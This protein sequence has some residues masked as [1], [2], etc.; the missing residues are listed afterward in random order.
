MIL[1]GHEN[2]V[3]V[4]FERTV[5]SDYGQTPLITLPTMMR[6][7][8]DVVAL[9]LWDGGRYE[10]VI[11]IHIAHLIKIRQGESGSPFR[12]SHEGKC[13]TGNPTTS[14]VDCRWWVNKVAIYDKRSSLHL[15]YRAQYTQFRKSAIWSSQYR[16]YNSL[17]TFHNLE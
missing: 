11:Q 17:R 16:S 6:T 9:P 5:I 8:V 14:K 13:K 2:T 4:I 10:T 1:H 15:I 7:R 3:I 12:T